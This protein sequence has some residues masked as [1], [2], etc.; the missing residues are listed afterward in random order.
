MGQLQAHIRQLASNSAAVVITPHAKSQMRKRGINVSLVY[1]S[2]REGR[3]LRRPEPSLQHGSLECR[4][5]R[6]AAGKNCCVVAAL[7][8]ETP[9]V[10]CVTVFYSN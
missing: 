4:M 9:N 1:E 6:Y 3:L 2:L 8:D 7:S 10:V 5:E